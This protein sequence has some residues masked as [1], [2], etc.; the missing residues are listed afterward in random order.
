MKKL[1]SIVLVLAMVCCVVGCNSSET[2][3]SK[4]GLEEISVAIASEWWA[5]DATQIDGTSYGHSLIADPI[6]LMDKDGNL[7]PCIASAVDISEDGKIIRLTFPK[8]LKF[9]NGADLTP[10]DVVA[11][12][13]RVHE[14]SPFGSELDVIDKM[15][16]EDMDVVIYLKDYSSSI[17]STLS[18]G[19]VTIMDTEDIENKSKEELRWGCMPYGQFSINDY[20]PGSH[21]TLT[22]NEY[23]KTNNPFV[24]NKGPHALKKIT[25]RFM[26]D[27]FAR[28]TAFNV[29]DVQ[30]ALSMSV[31]AIKQI[32]L[33]N[34]EKKTT[35]IANITYL[36]FNQDDPILSD[37]N[38]R[39]AIG[40]AID[41]QAICDINENINVPEYSI[42]GVRTFNHPEKFAEYYKKNY[43]N[44]VDEAKK[45]LEE[46]GWKDTDGNGYLDKDGEELALTL[47]SGDG[48]VESRS[49]QTIQLQLKEIGIKIDLELVESGYRYDKIGEGDFQFA[50][51]YFGASDPVRLLTWL[52]IVPENIRDHEKFFAILDEAS[53][54]IDSNARTKLIEDAERVLSDEAVTVPLFSI[55]NYYVHSEEL[56]GFTL[57]GNGNVLWNDV[58]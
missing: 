2:T 42:C 25:F 11:S 34:F 33:S 30:V 31:D 10:E 39:K 8:G 40:F 48:T 1:V 12:I 19:F 36:E 6:V 20:V 13:E 37:I 35:G 9:S 56:T 45:L 17:K 21:V 24:E 50:I 53:K 29:G 54:T 52:L 46:S 47:L 5:G 16:I 23:Y 43:C 32:T 27:D 38:V 14:V 15:E 58:Q 41:R 49:C 57:N 18:G 3:S 51:E 55:L 7:T 22:R 4:K 28:V 26:A 44:N